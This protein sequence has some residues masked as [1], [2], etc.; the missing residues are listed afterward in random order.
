M[1]RSHGADTSIQLGFRIHR[2]H[3][4]FWIPIPIIK[5]W[6]LASLSR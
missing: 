1:P 6:M 5:R 2:L 4:I 3:L